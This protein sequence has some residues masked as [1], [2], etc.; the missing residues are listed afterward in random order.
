LALSQI[1]GIESGEAAEDVLARWTAQGERPYGVWGKIIYDE[2]LE[3]SRSMLEALRP[4]RIGQRQ[5]DRELLVRI[6]GI[7]VSGVVSELYA[8]GRVDFSPA[9]IRA[10][11]RLSA[12]LR[13][14]I[15]AAGG[16]AVESWVV[17]RPKQGDGPVEFEKL[18][19][20]DVVWASAALEVFLAMFRLGQRAPLPFFPD[21][22]WDF[23]QHLEDGKSEAEALRSAVQ[24]FGGLDWSL[25]DGTRGRRCSREVQHLF[26]S[27]PPLTED[28]PKR[29]GIPEFPGFAQLAVAVFGPYCA[30][31]E[32]VALKSF[33]NYETYKD[34]NPGIPG[35]WG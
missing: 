27:E 12:W 29:F 33:P 25:G 15:L 4:L 11:Y 8:V 34:K 6:D 2:R 24:Q 23:V 22:A 13:H 16:Y 35:G 1:R 10:E 18:R 32:S 7:K 21:L 3:V 30:Q 31:S 20:L 5:P 17:R 14:L 28:W 26:G 19:S 9:R